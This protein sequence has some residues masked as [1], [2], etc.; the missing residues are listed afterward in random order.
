M[1]TYYVDYNNGSD[2]NNGL[3]PDASHASNKPWKTI[4]KLLGASGMASGDTAYLAPGVYRER[5]TVAMTSATGETL[6]IGDPLNAKGFKTS[7]GVLVTPAP[8]VHSP[9]E[10]SDTAAP[11]ATASTLNLSGR[12]YLTFRDIL[13]LA[14]SGNN[15]IQA[16]TNTSTNIK[17]QDCA[18]ISSGA[19]NSH[20][21]NFTA[22]AN[23]ALNLE[24]TRCLFVQHRSANC[25]TLTLTRPSGAD[26]NVAV[27]IQNCVFLQFGAS[28]VIPITTSGANVFNPGGV[29]IT[30]CS[31]LGA[32]S[33]S[34][35]STG[36]NVSTS[37]PVTVSNCI[38]AGGSTG[39]NANTSGQITEDYNRIGC[40]T[41]RSNVT[42][43]TNS[44]SDGSRV[45]LLEYGQSPL[46]GFRLLP[47][48]TPFVDGSGLDGWG[49]SSPP[50]TDY[51][52]RIRPAGG[53]STSAFPG[54]IEL[55]NTAA[56]ET[57]T[58]DSGSGL[59]IVG[60]G[61]HS[62]FVPV[63]ASSTTISIKA[64]YDTNHAATNKPQVILV[65]NDKIGVATETKTMTSAVDTWE[66]LTFS[67]FTPSAKGVV[68]IRLISRS[69]AGNGK[70]F[71]DTVT[72]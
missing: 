20:M 7:G 16:D 5:V 15:C 50:S 24:I 72:S 18:F 23:T 26:F 54:A 34:I 27:T 58:T 39:L 1:A 8:V 37:I 71:F 44:V 41:A 60:P 17:F 33:S 22:A 31:L 52:N 32:A 30:N 70:A 67:A 35:I 25:V 28:Q 65:A 3:G 42:A 46:F 51:L 59:V 55:H 13:W 11:S 43:G 68:E 63:D 64:R 29:S 12:D 57:T 21:V 19:A 56:L 66:T 53:Q 10:T 14:G 48:L 38:L 69:A 36:A 45:V 49:G 61:D 40:T 4:A 9:Y 6:V 62:I 2:S 47:F